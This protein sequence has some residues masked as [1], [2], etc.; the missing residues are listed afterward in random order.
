MLRQAMA[1]LALNARDVS[2]PGPDVPDRVRA[3]DRAWHGRREDDDEKENEQNGK[4]ATPA[5]AGPTRPSTHPITQT[6]YL[7][8]GFSSPVHPTRTGSLMEKV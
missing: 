8:K 4:V 7:T 3:A 5:R 6:E 2:L 1:D